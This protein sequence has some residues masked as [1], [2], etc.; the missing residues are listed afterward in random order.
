MMTTPDEPAKAQAE[1][2]LSWASRVRSWLDSF[3]EIPDEKG[4]DDDE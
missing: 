1:P 3:P 2:D 4:A